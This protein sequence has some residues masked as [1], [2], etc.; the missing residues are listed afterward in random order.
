MYN[1]LIE[2]HSNLFNG[3]H[4]LVGISESL[5]TIILFIA[6]DADVYVIAL[7]M[8]FILVHQHTKKIGSK[9]E[10]ASKL[11]QEMVLIT[12]SVLIAWMVSYS[13][14][15]AIGGLRP[16]EFYETL[17]PLFIYGGGDS[18]PSGHATLF[19]ALAL[20]LTMLHRRAGVIFV[21]LAIAIS[22]AR[23]ISGIHY[24][25]DIFAGWIIGGIVSY[26]VYVLVKKH[27]PFQKK[28]R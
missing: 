25:I 18:F 2:F 5:N 14:K 22:L 7:A 27:N 21:I 4:S 11:I 28:T 24:P 6:R 13:L 15:Y 9:P 19:S 8:L 1:L 17:T 12:A 3:L 10:K 23:V 26:V 20:M 16:Y